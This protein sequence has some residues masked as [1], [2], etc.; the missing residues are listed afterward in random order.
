M[1]ETVSY[2]RLAEGSGT[3]YKCSFQACSFSFPI[4]VDGGLMRPAIGRMTSVARSLLAMAR[5][6]CSFQACLFL[7]EGYL[8]VSATMAGG[9]R[10]R[11]AEPGRKAGTM[12]LLPSLHV[13]LSN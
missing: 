13:F 10:I 4:E 2:M 6:L 11:C 12:M 9:A 1:V 5:L 3:T 7:T 8:C